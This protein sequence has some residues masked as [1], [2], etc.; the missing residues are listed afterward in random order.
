MLSGRYSCA[1]AERPGT[2]SPP[3]NPLSPIIPAHPKPLPVSPIIPAHTQK[4]GVGGA[5]HT[6][7]SPVTLLFSSAMLTNTLSTIV[8]APTFPFLRAT[9][10]PPAKRARSTRIVATGRRAVSYTQAAPCVG[11]K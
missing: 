11:C 6:R 1:I 5:S 2:S 4:Q 3:K 8:G 9:Q 7:C 10:T